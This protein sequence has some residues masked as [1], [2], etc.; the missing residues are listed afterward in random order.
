[1]TS[2]N[3]IVQFMIDL[4]G[5]ITRGAR[6]A[7]GRPGEARRTSRA[8]PRPPIWFGV[9]ASLRTGNAGS[10]ERSDCELALPVG[11]RGHA[12][13]SALRARSSISANHFSLQGA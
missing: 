9:G 3:C 13:P 12:N 10:G 1:M 8:C 4:G 11:G 2:D 5:P 7:D 6:Y